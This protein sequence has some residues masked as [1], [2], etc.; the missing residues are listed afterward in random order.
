MH[1]QLSNQTD[2]LFKACL[3]YRRQGFD[4]KAAHLQVLLSFPSLLIFLRRSPVE[5]LQLY[6]P[7][8]SNSQIVLTIF[9]RNSYFDESNNTQSLCFCNLPKTKT[10]LPGNIWE[11]SLIWNHLSC[12]DALDQ[13][14]LSTVTTNVH[15][16]Y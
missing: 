7:D 9:S 3:T 5:N 15:V 8:H 6:Q 2:T 11:V 4:Q 10:C 16:Y 14:H 13:G 12:N 1:K